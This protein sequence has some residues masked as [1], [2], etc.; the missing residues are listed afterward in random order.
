MRL[1][2][3]KRNHFLKVIETCGES[4]A[5]LQF[6]IRCAT[7]TLNDYAKVFCHKRKLKAVPVDEMHEKCLEETIRIAK[8]PWLDD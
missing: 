8:T 2:Y 1:R 7:P 6:L 5:F 3:M 4:E